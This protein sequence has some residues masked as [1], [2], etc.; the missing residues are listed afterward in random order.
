MTKP[1]VGNVND[2][3]I[4]DDIDVS[5]RDWANVDGNTVDF[6]VTVNVD[7]NNFYVVDDSEDK[8]EFWVH[9]DKYQ[10]DIEFHVSW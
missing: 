8:I 5:K 9:D 3:C 4:V 1:H 2:F 6:G 7:D 10:N